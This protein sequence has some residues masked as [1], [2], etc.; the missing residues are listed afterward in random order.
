M[1]CTVVPMEWTREIYRGSTK[2]R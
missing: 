1:L 2:A